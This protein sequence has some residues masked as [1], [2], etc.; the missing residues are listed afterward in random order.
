MRVT[1]GDN[2][3]DY[4]GITVTQTVSLTTAKYLI[5][6][7]LSTYRA[8]FMFVDIKDYYYGTILANFEYMQMV[9]KDIPEEIIVQY[10]LRAL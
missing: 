7:T 8:K 5:N 10:N 9:L 6:S 1:V 3:L 2:K 4:P